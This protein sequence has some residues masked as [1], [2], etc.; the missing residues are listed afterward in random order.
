M[1]EKAYIHEYGNKKLEPEHQD[2]IDVL[3]KRFINYE[4]FTN[5]KILRNQLF[6]D[7]TTFI[8]GDHF[9]FSYIFRKYGLQP[10][11]DCYPKA[12]Q[13]YLKRDIRE[14]TIRNL[15]NSFDG[16]IP[17]IFV[18]PKLKTKLFTGFTIESPLDLYRLMEFPGNTELY[19]SPIVD[20]KAEYRVFVNNSK[21][22][23]IKRYN[24]DEGYEPDMTVVQNAVHD[25]ENS[26]ECTKA[27]GIDF[28]ILST[29]D[30][31][32]VEWNDGYALG[33][34]GLDKEVYTDLLLARWS[35]IMTEIFTP[36]Y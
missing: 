9:V 30:T 5:K 7:H 33:S 27:Y 21:I 3:E 34:Y 2:V 20:W 35:E 16:N 28:G 24:G 8:A 10:P 36:R 12:L 14:T 1:I 11:A 22:V 19:Y 26:E 23:G 32:L 4:L 18:K 29:G 13:H 25:L 17:Y 31:A 15:S 6:I